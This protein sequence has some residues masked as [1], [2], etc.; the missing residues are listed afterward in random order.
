MFKI[1]SLYISQWKLLL[2]AGDAG[3][4]LL[5]VACT[6]LLY[7]YTA[8]RPWDFL[9]QHKIVFLFIGVIY[10]VVLFIAD[11]Y[12]YLKDF[13]Q[14]INIVHVLIA[15]WIGSLLVVLILYFPIR[16]A[17]VG[18]SMIIIQA[19][20]FSILVACWRIGFSATVLI[21]R[22]RKRLLIIGAGK[23]GRHLYRSVH[24]RPGCGFDVVGFVD[25][26]AAKAGTDVDGLRVLGNS[27]QLSALIREHH[28]SMAAV[29]ITR[30]R[31]PQLID[32]LITVS[33]NECTLM[34]MPSLYEFLTGKLPTE[35][36]SNNW[37]FEWNINTTKIYYRRLKRSIDIILAVLFLSITFPILVLAALVIKID[38]RG[39]TFFHQERLGH[40]GK[41][42]N[43]LK[44]RTMV[45]NAAKCGP[46][47]TINNDP[48]ITRVGRFI[49]KLRIDEL[50]QL[51]NILKGEMSFIGPRPLAYDSSMDNIRYYHYRLLV[52]PGIT[53]W[54]QVM[55]PEGLTIDTTQEKL[56]YDLYYI[57]NIGLMLDLA[58][59]L[60][61]VR[62][63]IFGKGC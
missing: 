28:V 48:R 14:I 4:Y 12:D 40:K 8:A 39:P 35:H 13:R 45:E 27:S 49:R 33:W 56:K 23:A 9:Y 16:G 55:F 5:S 47:W 62:T 6:L 61:T 18:R 58:I 3:C 2:I 22:M 30:E 46:V 11:L 29:A 21:H 51:L 57:K 34:D 1:F 31:S 50:P 63:V 59:F 60:K 7:P 53:G 52:K 41:I 42:F 36:I 19:V 38:S 54:A 10:F 26:D 43:I 32:N 20:F 17:Y 44:F 37:I 24:T 15:C 25:D